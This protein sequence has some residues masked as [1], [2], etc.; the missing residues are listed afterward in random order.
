MRL[1]IFTNRDLASNYHLNL[2]LPHLHQ[3]VKAIF[4]SDK[5]GKK[6]ETPVP[7]ALRNLKFFE[8]TLP[9]EILFPQL[10]CQNRNLQN[11]KLLTFNELSK[12]Y[13]IPMESLNEVQSTQTLDLIRVLK[14]DL[15]LSV[16][17]GKIFKEAFIKIPTHGILNLHSGKLPQ[18]R[19]VLASFR[20]LMNGDDLLQTTL[21]YIK[22]GQIDNG[23]IIGFSNLPVQKDKSLFW[24]ILNLYPVSIAL[25][26]ATIQQIQKKQKPVIFAQKEADAQ[27]FTFPNQAEMDIFHQKGYRLMDVDDYKTFI[28]QYL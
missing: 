2:L 6:V 25:V 27:Y 16:R 22:D 5:V 9:N 21:H 17:Y 1:I 14:P 23:G 15:I 11:T 10:D 3:Q 13:H 19:G 8:Q 20:A 4:L 28:Q 7:E 24:H 12:K 26:V 18:Y